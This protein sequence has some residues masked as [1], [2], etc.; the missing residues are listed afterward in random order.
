MILGGV[1]S[2]LQALT[3]Y[4][5]RWAITKNGDLLR[6]LYNHIT[7]KGWESI[8]ISKVK[9]HITE[10]MVEKDEYTRE[11][12]EGNDGGDEAANFGAKDMQPEEATLAG[13][14]S[15][16][17]WRY[18]KFMARIQNFI[19]KMRT[20]MKEERKNLKKQENPMQDE[21]KEKIAIPIKLDYEEDDKASRH[22]NIRK[23]EKHDE[24]EEE[25]KVEMEKVR[26]FLTHMKWQQEQRQTGGITWLELY[27]LS[28]LHGGKVKLLSPC[29]QTR[30]VSLQTAIK[31]F[32]R[33]TRKVALHCVRKE[34]E[35]N[36]HTC[37]ARRNRLETIAISNKHAAIK[38]MPQMSDEDARRISSAILAMR[39]VNQRKKKQ[40]HQ[41]GNLKLHRRPLAYKGLSR[42]WLRNFTNIKDEE[43]WTKAPMTADEPSEAKRPLNQIGCPECGHRQDSANNKFRAKTGFGQMTCQRCRRITKSS[44]WRC[45]CGIEWHRC[46]MHVHKE[47]LKERSLSTV[48]LQKG[49][50]SNKSN[51]GTDEP[52]PKKARYAWDGIA[53]S[54]QSDSSTRLNRISLAPEKCPKLAERFPHLVK[55]AVPT[56]GDCVR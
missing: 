37:N 11:E 2:P 52:P 22:L 51:M 27:I 41:D 8:K 56:K 31:N 20:A 38:G 33:R 48:S 7:A 19:I 47:C 15:R 25:E 29:S 54:A 10:E 46:Q 36:F 42:A 6:N 49:V 17:H 12:K 18:Q 35:W 34:D 21:E 13:F 39:G 16:R 14:Y 28:I 23:V 4:K 32:K 50:G 30:T 53:I 24:K 55:A 5:R 43:D 9:A 45:D 1:T 26:C 3:P 44:N 40:A